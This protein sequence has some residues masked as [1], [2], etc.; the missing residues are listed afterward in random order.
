MRIAPRKRH[1]YVLRSPRPR[2][3]SSSAQAA[4]DRH[5]SVG[6]CDEW[7]E[8]RAVAKLVNRRPE[9]ARTPP[10]T[11][12]G[13]GAGAAPARGKAARRVSIRRSVPRAD[14]RRSHFGRT[15]TV[16]R[17]RAGTSTSASIT[18]I[19]P[20]SDWNDCNVVP[21]VVPLERAA[22]FDEPRLRPRG[23]GAWRRCPCHPLPLRPAHAG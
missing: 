16:A 10:A 11:G 17:A 13:R 3:Q 19:V 5:A 21:Q 23:E 9:Q 18:V 2:S 15:P 14:C 20:A 1:R 22:V 4:P 12:G 8:V 7:P 6:R